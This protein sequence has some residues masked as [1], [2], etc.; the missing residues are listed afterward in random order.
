MTIGEFAGRAAAL[1]CCADRLRGV[2]LLYVRARAIPMLGQGSQGDKF[3]LPEVELMHTIFH[4]IKEPS[5]HRWD[6]NAYRVREP[7]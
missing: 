1:L 3:T 4:P 6:L 7:D 2:L 5:T